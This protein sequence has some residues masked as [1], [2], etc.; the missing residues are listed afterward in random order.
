MTGLVLCG[1]Q[2][3]RMGTDKGLLKLHG[4]TWAEATADKLNAL[5]LPVILSVNE[6]QYQT[7]ISLFTEK[8]IIRDNLSLGIRGPLCGVLS[9]HLLFP[10]EDLFVLAC[11]MPLL[12]VK[13]LKNLMEAV[14]KFPSSGAVLYD[15]NGEPEPLCG[16]Y[17]ASSLA[18]VVMLQQQGSLSKHSMKYMLE[19]MKPTLLPL[20]A[21][22]QSS[23]RNFNVS[24]ELNSL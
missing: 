22:Q 6:Q 24:S 4:R 18:F 8:Q 21:D 3:S 15:N 20:R 13:V 23:F 5:A 19:Q 9:A 2:S 17:R 16:I 10:D 7:Y 12:D 11:D 14:E 1:G